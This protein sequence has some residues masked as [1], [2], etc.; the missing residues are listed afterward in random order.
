MDIST[1]WHGHIHGYIHGHIHGY[2][3]GY[4][5]PRQ[6]CLKLSNRFRLQIDAHDPIQRAEFVNAPK[7]YL[8]KRDH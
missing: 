3:H 4:P 5:Y 2:I 7:L 1:A 6:A 8:C